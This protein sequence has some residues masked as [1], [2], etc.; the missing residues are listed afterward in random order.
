MVL[1]WIL[2]RWINQVD[3]KIDGRL[4][5]PEPR[6]TGLLGGLS[7]GYAGKVT[8]AVSV[9]PRLEP[10]PQFGVKHEQDS[11]RCWIHDQRRSGE[12]SGTTSA[13]QGISIVVEQLKDS[14]AGRSRWPRP[15]YVR[16]LDSSSPNQLA[17]IE[18]FTHPT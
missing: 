4:G 16:R 9:S 15:H 18:K 10:T 8:V 5:Y 14:V 11:S 12:V 17:D 6:N 3:V 7:Q 2:C 13:V 1:M